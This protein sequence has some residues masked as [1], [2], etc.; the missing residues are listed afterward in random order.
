MDLG[1][2]TGCL[3]SSGVKGPLGNAVWGPGRQTQSSLGA[4]LMFWILGWDLSRL[5]AGTSGLVESSLEAHIGREGM[6]LD[7]LVGV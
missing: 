1:L 7:W 3:L 4:I 2:E 6:G 5:H